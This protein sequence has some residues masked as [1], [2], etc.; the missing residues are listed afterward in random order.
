MKRGGGTILS[1][2]DVTVPSKTGCFLLYYEKEVDMI[3]DRF[4]IQHY[5]DVSDYMKCIYDKR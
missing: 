3:G 2:A 4:S 5:C 1:G